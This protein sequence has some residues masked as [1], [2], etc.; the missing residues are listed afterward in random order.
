MQN[1]C[2]FC[3]IFME[4]WQAPYLVISDFQPADSSFCF[5]VTC[6]WQHSVSRLWQTKAF[7]DQLCLAKSCHKELLA[8]WPSE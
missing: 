1:K 5:S 3:H 8:V 2:N 4:H 6:P 7:H